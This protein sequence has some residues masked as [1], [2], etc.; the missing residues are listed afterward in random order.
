MHR[1]MNTRV[2]TDVVRDAQKFLT[3]QDAKET[4]VSTE[5]LDVVRSNTEITDLN[6][7]NR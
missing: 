1:S 5:G 6:N 3:C 2:T 7:F 4:E